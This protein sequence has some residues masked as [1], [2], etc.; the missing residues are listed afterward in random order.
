MPVFYGNFQVSTII[1]ALARFL[2][3]A[4]VLL[5]KSSSSS[6]SPPSLADGVYSLAI[7]AAFLFPVFNL[8]RSFLSSGSFEGPNLAW[9]ETFAPNPSLQENVKDF[10]EQLTISHQH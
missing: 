9:R 2:S 10:G 3:N 1:G 6:L 5:S 4:L 8:A 7:I